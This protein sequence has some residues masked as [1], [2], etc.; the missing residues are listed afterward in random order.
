MED[1]PRSSHCEE[2]R[3]YFEPAS[4]KHVM[5][6]ALRVKK[7]IDTIVT[8]PLDEN[9]INSPHSPVLTSPIIKLVFDAAG[10]SGDGKVGSSSRRF[11]APLIFVLLTVKRWN[12]TAAELTLYDA[13]LYS[14]RGLVAEYI[15]QSILDSEP[16][17]DYV[18][19]DMLCQ[20]Y[21]IWVH[22]KNSRPLNALELAV[23]LH[24]TVVI[25]S[26]GYQRCMKWLWRGWI[27][28]SDLDRENSK[29]QYEFY[30]SIADTRVAS[31]FDSD[32]IRVP[33]YQTW[34]ELFVSTM[35]LLLY[36]V[37]VNAA[38]PD[39]PMR[40]YE[41][42]LYILTVGFVADEVIKVYKVGGLYLGFWNIL[43]DTLYTLVTIAFIL[44]CW[45]LA[46]P[47]GS[48]AREQNDT[49]AYDI[50]SCA[51]PLVWGRMLLYLD[52]L[53]FFGSMLSVLKELMAQSLIFFVL[54]VVVG[55]GFLQAFIGL[56]TADGARDVTIQV[57]RVMVHTLL[58]APEFEWMDSFAPPY[59]EV[60]YYIFVFLVLV[61]LVNI[62]I[63][64]F[65]SAY[66][67]IY[68]NATNE[69]LAN[70]AQKTL[71][72]IR[73][74]D[75][76]VFI[77]PLNL[78]EIIILIPLS[79]VLSEDTCDSIVKVVMEILY[80]PFLLFISISEARTAKLVV[81]NRS[82]GVPDDANEQDTEWDLFDGYHHTAQEALREYNELEEELANDPDFAIDEDKWMQAIER[83]KPKFKER[84]VTYREFARLEKKIDELL[85]KARGNP[86]QSNNE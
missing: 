57:S 3:L 9:V 67:N 52:S 31:H 79:W 30:K 58:T 49:S 55:V 81:Y 69:Y 71:R 16:D 41:V 13:D 23:D 72:F 4:A 48:T 47:E 24:S 75:E 2:G 54:L 61:I 46:Q 21:S 42:A 17:T 64:L 33:K 37:A 29:R 65:N 73:A 83:N 56:D 60:L 27:M 28:R 82:R 86:D 36:T 45:A 44:R 6:I 26:A 35:Y 77:P 5:K 1:R 18:L 40:A 43:N 39:E 66:S 51:A 22:G 76:N 25:S 59:G 15:A 7:L 32:R 34:I 20:Q 68:D 70:V 10:G 38:S 63:A 80:A 62:L 8:C 53:L 14:T 78:I 50:L 74:P 84:T 11:R 85:S 19:A 12:D